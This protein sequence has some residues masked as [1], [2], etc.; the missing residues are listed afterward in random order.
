MGAT[1]SGVE[2]IV[3]GRYGPGGT[4]SESLVR[5]RSEVENVGATRW[6]EGHG[7][8]ISQEKQH[9]GTTCG[10]SVLISNVRLGI[11]AVLDRG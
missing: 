5:V 11:Q 10:C 7:T 2:W 1:L 8:S 6:R 9:P 3:A 4:N